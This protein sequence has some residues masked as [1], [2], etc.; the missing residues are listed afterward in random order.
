MCTCMCFVVMYYVP[1]VDVHRRDHSRSQQITAEQSAEC[2]LVLISRVRGRP[3]RE[4][5]PLEPTECNTS[6]QQATDRPTDR[7]SQSERNP[8][9]PLACDTADV[10]HQIRRSSYI[11][12]YSTLRVG[13]ASTSSLSTLPP[14]HPHAP[15]QCLHDSSHWTTSGHESIDLV[16]RS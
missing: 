7:M 6:V 8:G 13:T 11:W 2:V 10:S 15:M 16:L 12:L 4:R 5:A 14:N 1:S 9:G 3:C